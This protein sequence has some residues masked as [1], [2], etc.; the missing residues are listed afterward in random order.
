MNRSRGRPQGLGPR[1]SQTRLRCRT[2]GRS[3]R[4]GLQRS[5]GPARAGRAQPV[6]RPSSV[7]CGVG[8]P[9]PQGTGGSAGQGGAAAVIASGAA[10][11]GAAKLRGRTAAPFGAA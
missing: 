3:A 9:A 11:A 2:A 10:A 4:W 7:P 8:A 6:L 5:P 1:R